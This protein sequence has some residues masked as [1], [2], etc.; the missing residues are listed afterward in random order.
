M[1]VKEVVIAAAARTP[2]GS[3]L[4]SLSSFTAPELG[5]FAVAEAL[6]RS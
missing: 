6:K 1:C 3:Y 2:I 5:G 4:S